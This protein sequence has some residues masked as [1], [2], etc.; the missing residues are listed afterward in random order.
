[1]GIK[2]LVGIYQSQT[3]HRNF[4]EMKSELTWNSFVLKY[5]FDSA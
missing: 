1:M 2:E 5:N 3:L 4:I